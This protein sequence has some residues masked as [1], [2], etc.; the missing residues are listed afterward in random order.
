MSKVIIYN[1]AKKTCIKKIENNENIE[2]ATKKISNDKIMYEKKSYLD[3]VSKVSTNK[4]NNEVNDMS[5]S[6]LNIYDN[7]T[8]QL[9][10]IQK[11]YNGT[12]FNEDKY[13]IRALK[14]KLDCYKQQDQSN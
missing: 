1:S 9:V 5:G 2:D 11:L 3:L 10:L 8:M 4:V 6:I 14:Y 13:F 12:P 7:Y